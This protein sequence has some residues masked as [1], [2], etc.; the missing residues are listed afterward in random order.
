[1][2]KKHKRQSRPPLTVKVKPYTYQPSKAELNADMSLPATPEQL[3]RAVLQDVT[4]KPLQHA[5]ENRVLSNKEE[6]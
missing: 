4:I 6:S 2:T 3:A 5:R 1:M